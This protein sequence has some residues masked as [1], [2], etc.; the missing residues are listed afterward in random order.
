MSSICKLK[1]EAGMDFANT[2]TAYILSF[3]EPIVC[4]GCGGKFSRKY[5]IVQSQSQRAAIAQW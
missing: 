3:I 4:F 2:L 5:L 1:V